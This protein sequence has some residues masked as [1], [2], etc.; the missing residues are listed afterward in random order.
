MTVFVYVALLLLV[1]LNVAFEHA[2]NLRL[3]V[4]HIV[5]MEQPEQLAALIVEHLAPLPRWS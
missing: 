2:L 1:T 4:A 3:H 5:G